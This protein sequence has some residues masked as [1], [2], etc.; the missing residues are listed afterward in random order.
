MKGMIGAVF[1]VVVALS[2]VGC[3]SI[4]TNELAPD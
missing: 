2:G 3:A 4:K 1:I